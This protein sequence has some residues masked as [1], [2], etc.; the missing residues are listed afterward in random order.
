MSKECRRECSPPNI[1]RQSRFKPVARKTRRGCFSS[2]KL[3]PSIYRPSKQ[4]SQSMDWLSNG[5]D[6]RNNSSVHE[7]Q[8]R[9]DGCEQTGASPSTDRAADRRKAAPARWVARAR[10]CHSWRKR[11]AKNQSARTVARLQQEVMNICPSFLPAMEELN[12][13]LAA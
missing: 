9:T 13:A 4:L 1:L 5:R 12:L 8:L 7:L 11:S 10:S 3:A 6:F 2:L